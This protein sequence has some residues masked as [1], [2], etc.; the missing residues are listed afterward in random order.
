[1]MIFSFLFFC[2][3]AQAETAP[4][5][6]SEQVFSEKNAIEAARTFKKITDDD[7]QALK[8]DDQRQKWV[9][10]RLAWIALERLKGQEEEAIR[11]F[12][13]CIEGSCEKFGQKNEW[14]AVKT[15]AC[16]KKKEAIPCL[17]KTEAPKPPL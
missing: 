17:H 11:I 2:M 9:S 3:G 4:N 10:A 5:I 13:G 7:F 14:I 15:W 6:S 8:T 12:S 1:M 16:G